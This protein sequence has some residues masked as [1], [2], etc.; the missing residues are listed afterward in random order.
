MRYLKDKKA[1]PRTIYIEIGCD[2]TFARTQPTSRF[3]VRTFDFVRPVI[4]M[5]SAYVSCVIRNGTGLCVAG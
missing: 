3:G 5:A 1:T 4:S 2:V